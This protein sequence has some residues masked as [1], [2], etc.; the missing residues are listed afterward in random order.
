LLSIDY[1]GVEPVSSQENHQDDKISHSHISTSPTEL[2]RSQ[3]LVI[4][5][6]GQVRLVANVVNVLPHNPVISQLSCSNP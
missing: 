5:D 2:L 1:I 4:D 3:G 6:R